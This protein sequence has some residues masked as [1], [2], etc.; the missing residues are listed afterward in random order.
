MCDCRSTN[1][2]IGSVP[3]CVLDPRLYFR[4]ATR[5]VSIDA[6]IADQIEWLWKN[7][8]FTRGSCCGHSP[9]P[10]HG[11]TVCID[12]DSDPWAAKRLLREID[13]GRSWTVTKYLNVII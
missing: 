11:P 5:T 4:K 6:C 9:S 1:M 3:E 2:N 13:P 7:G 12:D 8:I 10:H